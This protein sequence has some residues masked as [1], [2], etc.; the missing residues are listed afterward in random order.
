MTGPAIWVACPG[1]YS[2]R[3][4]EQAVREHVPDNLRYDVTQEAVVDGLNQEV[5][6]IRAHPTV[7]ATRGEMTWSATAS[8]AAQ[9]F[10]LRESMLPCVLF[11]D[12]LGSGISAIAVPT[13]VSLY[14]LCKAVVEELGDTVV[15]FTQSDREVSSAVSKERTAWH[16]FSKQRA[17]VTA[18][19]ARNAE[20]RPRSLEIVDQLRAIQ[21]GDVRHLQACARTIEATASD[22]D[23]EQKLC[24]TLL[25][26]R[27]TLMT[28][29]NGRTR[30][31]NQKIKRLAE[32]IPRWRERILSADPR[33]L[34]EFKAEAQ[35]ATERRSDA[36]A[37]RRI[38]RSKV[39]IRAAVRRAATSLFGTV[40][41]ECIMLKPLHSEVQDVDTWRGIWFGPRRVAVHHG[42]QKTA[43]EWRRARIAGSLGFGTA[44]LTSGLAVFI[45]YATSDG[46]GWIPWAVSAVLTLVTAILAYIASAR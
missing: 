35:A 18:E 23:S 36:E 34:S 21:I 46:T 43:D 8:R 27:S 31:L 2:N 7:S 22:P 3:D 12:L 5:A 11:I 13:N 26:A 17:A 39:N 40:N 41:E 9:A 1:E 29:H 28:I 6:Q 42:S 16:L 38:A 44:V 30:G 25:S 33:P 15:Q 4:F 24:N 37:R 32:D 19:G 14:D 45:N 20:L 10:G